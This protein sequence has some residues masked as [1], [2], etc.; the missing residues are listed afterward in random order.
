MELIRRNFIFTN[1]FIFHLFNFYLGVRMSKVLLLS[2]CNKKI[3]L[4][5]FEW[6]VVPFGRPIPIRA[7]K[8]EHLDKWPPILSASCRVKNCLFVP[9]NTVHIRDSSKNGIGSLVQRIPKHTPVKG[10][11]LLVALVRRHSL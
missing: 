3:P 7:Q 1:L 11:N 10:V 4:G 5:V 6:W 2:N 9:I 8:K